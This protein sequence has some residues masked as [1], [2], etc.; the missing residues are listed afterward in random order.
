[1]HLVLLAQ[2]AT[3]LFMTGLI[4]L[5]QVVHYPLFAEVGPDHFHQYHTYHSQWI[6]PIVG[7]IMLAELL[8]AG[9]L[10][11]SAP[12]F[13][14]GWHLLLGLGLIILIWGSTA[15][16]QIPLHNELSRN[17]SL[18]S[19]HKLVAGNWIRTVAWTLRSALVLWWSYLAI[20]H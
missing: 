12:E 8:T 3:T 5:V 16:V 7:P 20:I 15:V 9:L 6:T 4:W 17:F 1:M 14:P 18:E 10:I 19:V 11:Q 2:I 13:I